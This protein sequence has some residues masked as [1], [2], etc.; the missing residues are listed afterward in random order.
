[1]DSEVCVLL[2]GGLDSYVAFRL[3][4]RRHG[5]ENIVGMFVNYGQPYSAKELQAMNSLHL[6]ESQD[7]EVIYAKANWCADALAGIPTPEKQEIPG[8]NL[9]LALYGSL[10]AS[11]VWISALEN[12]VGGPNTVPDKRPEFFMQTS[13]L[14]SSILKC[15][16]PTT[17]VTTPFGQLTKTEV[18]RLG[19]MLGISKH[20]LLNT[21]SCFDGTVA[22]PCGV[23]MACHKRW[24]AFINNGIDTTSHYLA[25]PCSEKNLYYKKTIPEMKKQVS[26]GLGR[27]TPKRIIET[28]MALLSRGYSLFEWPDHERFT[29][30]PRLYSADELVLLANEGHS[31][32][33]L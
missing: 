30:Y 5:A 6:F 18:V 12:E 9:L 33:V 14:L 11:E 3:A 24:V 4:Q 32:K 2:S 8:R 17:L 29:S 15:L 23:C 10:R 21:V 20:D 25:D 31:F 27:F 19:A 28:H 7:S 16:R 1:M 13:A 22:K 26:E